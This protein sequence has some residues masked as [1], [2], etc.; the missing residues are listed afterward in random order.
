LDGNARPGSNAGRVILISERSVMEVKIGGVYRHYKGNFYVVENIV[1]HSE[2]LEKMVLYR[3]LYGDGEL[4]VRPLKMW[5]EIVN[6]DGQK[7]RFELV[8]SFQEAE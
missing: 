3:A 7:L 4:W 6:Q 5:S 1:H 8:N 2:T